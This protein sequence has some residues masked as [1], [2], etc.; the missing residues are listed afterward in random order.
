ML[1]ALTSAVHLDDSHCNLP[2]S[3]FWQRHIR[4]LEVH[5]GDRIIAKICSVSD[6][7]CTVFLWTL[8]C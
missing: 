5:I 8:A 2:E 3:K 6:N 1:V 7:M 4:T